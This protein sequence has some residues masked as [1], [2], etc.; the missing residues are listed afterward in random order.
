[1]FKAL[2]EHKHELYLLEQHSDSF[3]QQLYWIYTED[4]SLIMK[5]APV[6]DCIGI[7]VTVGKLIPCM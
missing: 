6:H 4:K 5:L 7:R 3:G 1:M 2:R